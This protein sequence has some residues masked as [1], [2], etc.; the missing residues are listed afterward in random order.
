MTL[1]S[2]ILRPLLPWVVLSLV[3]AGLSVRTSHLRPLDSAITAPNLEQAQGSTTSG[4]VGPLIQAAVTTAAPVYTTAKTSP[5]SQDTAGNLRV[6]D[7]RLPT[8][9]GQ[10]TMSASLPVNIASD[11]TKVPVAPQAIS[12]GG[13][14]QT[15]KTNVNATVQN[16]KVSAGTLYG[17]L[18][19]NTTAAA[20]FVQ[21]FDVTSGSITVGTTPPSQMHLVPAGSSMLLSFPAVGVAFLTAI[22]V[23]S[24]TTATGNTGSAS[25][26]NVTAFYQ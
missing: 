5:L 26:M 6:L 8:A 9:L 1:R 13:A 21:V 18:L 12:S 20:A 24:T 7:A 17:L 2:P 3:C 11:Q 14:T 4:Q 19:T 23:A 16:V 25:G 22:N 10:T 15:V